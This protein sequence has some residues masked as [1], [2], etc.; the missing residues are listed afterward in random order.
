MNTIRT[1]TIFDVELIQQLAYASWWPTYESFLPHQQ[2]EQMLA[3]FYNPQALLEQMQSGH[4]FVLIQQDQEPFG[5][6]SYRRLSSQIIRIEKLYL[7]PTFQGKGGGARLLN[8]VA[9]QGIAEGYSIIELNV[10]RFNPSLN[11]YIRKGFTIH[12]EVDIP[13]REFILNDYIM[14]KS[15]ATKTND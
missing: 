1:A 13:Y 10:N 2:I 7:L 3:D 9:D 6:V 14:H 8:Y 12:E 5:F 11:F 15:L 4:Q